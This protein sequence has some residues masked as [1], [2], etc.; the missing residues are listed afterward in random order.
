MSLS[1]TTAKSI[2]VVDDHPVNRTLMAGVI[3]R[4][5]YQS[6]EAAD[7][8]EAL[9]SV[10][11]HRPDLVISDILMPMIDGFEFV[12][13][14]RS[15]PALAHTK[16][17]FCTATYHEE[18]AEELAK[19]VGV[20][21]ILA[22]P[23]KPADLLEAVELA[24]QAPGRD[25][26][27]AAPGVEDAH[28][29]LITRKLLEQEAA[30]LRAHSLARLAHVITRPDGSFESWSRT[31]RDVTGLD[32][33]QIP[34]STRA[35]M[36]LIHPDWRARFRDKCV[37]AARSGVLTEV[38]YV[39]RR[40][41]GS[42]IH[43]QQVMEPMLEDRRPGAPLRWFTT[44]QDVTARVKAEEEVRRLN[45]DLE[46]R[47]AE[48]TI[49]LE[50]A[51]AEL[52]S[53]D[54][55]VSHDLRA[56]IDRIVGFTDALASDHSAQLDDAGRDLLRRISNAGQQMEQLVRDLFSL[57]TVSRGELRRSQVDI[58]A[59]AREAAA[60]L[61]RAHPDRTVAVEVEDGLVAWADPGLVRIVIE[62]LLANAWKFTRQRPQA[63]IRVGR[64]AAEAIP[65]FFVEDNG[66]G[67]D[68]QFAAKLFEPFR[69][70]HSAKDFEGTGI[71]LAT[72]RRIV[73][74]HGGRAW[75]QGAV[76]EGATMRFTLSR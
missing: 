72:I 10:A 70:L 69:R 53:F 44:L 27:A 29:Q 17:I 1:E 15:D 34:R 23:C 3:R 76:N 55:S 35:W 45:Q 9:R 4:G 51:M 20:F 42:W 47:V 60:G 61:A 62:N 46:R 57:S 33:D 38:E 22:K 37:A 43:I 2:L 58:S 67:F 36:D 63:R 39:L 59:I 52:E 65:T 73:S 56:P 8:A 48:R 64:D 7:G 66:A 75:A 12:R 11:A 41:D 26:G 6:M 5:G 40:Y 19:K 24:L 18:E 28:L 16:V 31:M 30:L 54:Y 13:R 50:A 68:P 74:R 14:L 21:R 49:E 25:H 32:D 71:G